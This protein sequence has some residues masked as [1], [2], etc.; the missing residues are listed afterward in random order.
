MGVPQHI[1]E[2][3]RISEPEDE[4]HKLSQ[5][6]PEDQL[7]IELRVFKEIVGGKSPDTEIN[8]NLQWQEAQ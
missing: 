8:I 5:S 2:D 6:I 7:F 4:Q 3:R 1:K